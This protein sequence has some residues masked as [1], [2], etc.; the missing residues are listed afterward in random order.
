[1]SL[2]IKKYNSQVRRAND[3]DGKSHCIAKTT[4]S[5]SAPVHWRGGQ[6]R[7]MGII[8]ACHNAEF[9]QI[10]T[11]RMPRNASMSVPGILIK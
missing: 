9:Q 1:M 2:D 7:P 8:I 6:Q 5:T 4:Q 3:D 11:S 10:Q